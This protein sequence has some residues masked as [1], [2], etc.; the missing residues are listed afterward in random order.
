[1]TS[2]AVLLKDRLNVTIEARLTSGEKR[3]ESDKTAEFPAPAHNHETP[4]AESNW[5][6]VYCICETQDDARMA[7]ESGGGVY[8]QS[9]AWRP[10]GCSCNSPRASVKNDTSR[11][12]HHFRR[13]GRSPWFLTL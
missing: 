2:D 10:R 13:A 8:G 4:T 12:R 1:M 5:E 6:L 9:E 7:A 11:S 3:R